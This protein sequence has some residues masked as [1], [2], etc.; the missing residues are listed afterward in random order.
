MLGSK[1]QAQE[2]PDSLEGAVGESQVLEKFRGVYQALYN[3]AG[4]EEKVNHLKQLMTS[5]ID[6]QSESEVRKV[7]AQEV[8]EACKKMKGGKMDVSQT[9][10]MFHLA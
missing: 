1:H 10:R 4:S 8:K 2:I 9:S 3:S 7:T 5:M 6:C